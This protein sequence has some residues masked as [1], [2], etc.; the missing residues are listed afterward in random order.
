MID[1]ANRWHLHGSAGHAYSGAEAGR[2]LW[3]RRDWATLDTWFESDAGRLLNVVTNGERAMVALL[4]GEGDPGE[5]LVDPRAEGT[6][7]GYPLPNGQVDGYAD[8]D[9]VP[10]DVA[11]RAVGYFI[12]HGTWP[13]EVTVEDDRGA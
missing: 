7:G 1:A 13:A 2:L 10:F 6:S 12:D 3:H 11:T 8:R 4:N 9:T 5:H